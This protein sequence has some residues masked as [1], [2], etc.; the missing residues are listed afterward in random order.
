[1]TLAFG[2]RK[3]GNAWHAG[4]IHDVDLDDTAEHAPFGSSA[5]KAGRN[6]EVHYYPGDDHRLMPET[7]NLQHARLVAFFRRHLEG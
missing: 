3:N 5:K 6:P 2:Y 7:Q 4:D 1:V